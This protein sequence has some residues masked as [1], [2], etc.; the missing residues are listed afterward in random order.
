MKNVYTN[1][2]YNVMEFDLMNNTGHIMYIQCGSTA[3]YVGF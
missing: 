2:L 3:F 1:I